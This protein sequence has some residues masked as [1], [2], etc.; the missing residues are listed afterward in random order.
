MR[1]KTQ[2]LITIVTF[3]IILIIIG[4]SIALTQQQIAE[5]NNQEAFAHDLQ[6]GASDLNYISNNYLLYQDNSSV[7]LWQVKFSSLCSDLQ[8]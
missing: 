3:S 4:A 6:T 2:F 7:G 8:N 1:I 5:F